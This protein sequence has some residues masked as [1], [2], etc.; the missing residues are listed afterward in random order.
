MT[1]LN[2][3]WRQVQWLFTRKILGLIFCLSIALFVAARKYQQGRVEAQ[4]YELPVFVLIIITGLAAAAVAL[5]R[6]TKADSAG[7]T[8]R[9]PTGSVGNPFLLVCKE[10]RALDE[11]EEH[12]ATSY[13]LVT[14]SLFSL[15]LL[16]IAVGPKFAPNEWQP[17]L[18]WRVSIVVLGIYLVQ[19]LVGNYRYA[20]RLSAHY[21]C[22]YQIL[23]Q[24]E[25]KL[26]LKVAR[27]L[28]DARHLEFGKVA[29]PTDDIDVAL[30]LLEALRRAPK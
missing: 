22:A 2:W 11:R 8:A 15:L 24:S 18:A 13:G 21:R 10:L 27:Q 26:P 6:M 29:A 20:R 30:K 25:G 3:L 1:V 5:D 16:L 7:E 28:L 19:L 17:W 4:D 9:N 14:Y 12:T 23:L